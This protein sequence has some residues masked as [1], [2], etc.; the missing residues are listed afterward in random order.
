MNALVVTGTDTGIG[1]T[2]VAAMLTLALD[3]VY[4]K[5]VQAGTLGG[6]DTSTVAAITG[7]SEERFIRERYLLTEPVS[8]HRAAELDGIHI[9]A[10]NLTPPENMP[11]DRVLIIEGAGGL[12]VPLTRRTLYIDLFE[13][14]GV[15]VML[16]A[17]TTLGTINHSLLSIE[18]L[19]T[20]G[21]PIKGIVFVG[22]SVPDSE[23]TI[24]EFATVP[25]LGR[26]PLLPRL[27][28]ALLV[29]AFETEFRRQ[30]FLDP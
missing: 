24:C 5:P 10:D 8:P 27:T 25:R 15:P 28:P 9:D 11:R 23:Q 13:R 7:L 4:W 6:T 16:C 3:G 19:R 18:A 17:R 12:M 21:I 2:V 14:W 26:L 1:K 20:R 22:D 29:A 30:D